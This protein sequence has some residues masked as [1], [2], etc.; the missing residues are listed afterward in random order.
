MNWF[1]NLKVRTRLLAAF[2]VM[3]LLTAIVGVIGIRNMSNMNDMT[4]K[5]Y[6]SELLGIA[7]IKEASLDLLRMVRAEKNLILSSTEADR[8]KFYADH[9]ERSKQL[10]NELNEAK[11]LFYSDQGKEMMA[12]IEGVWQG[13]QPVS[14]HL[15][16]VALA[17]NLQNM[18]K[19]VEI[20]N[21]VGREKVS[22]LNNLI[23]EATTH[24]EGEAK[25]FVEE[26]ASLYKDSRLFMIILIVGSICF[27]ISIGILI[28]IG[29]T[30]Q[31]GGEPGYI[32]DVAGKVAGGDLMVKF[33]SSNKVDTGVFV[34]MKVM[35]QK[36]KEIINDINAL[37]E[38]AREGQ[39]KTRADISRHQGDFAKIMD[40]INKTLDG[41]ITPL[42]TSAGYM[43][44]LSKGNIPAQ[45]T[46]EYKGDFNDIKKSINTM[47]ENLTGFATD[48]RT[49]ADNVA[50]G[51]QQ[52]SAGSEQLSQG[53]TEQAANAEEASSSVEEMSATIKQNA[54][55]A[56][57]TQKIAL[58][59]ASDAIE[60]GKAVSEAVIAMKDIAKKI[61]IIEEIAR[62]TNLLAL[63][64]AIEAAR[65]GEHGKGFAVVAAEV[66][67]LAERSQEA[68]GEIGQLS[69][70]SVE[71]AEKA[72]EMLSK[73]VP[74][75]QKTAELV[76]EITAASK[77]QTTG[78]DQINN[79][80]Q[81]LNQVIQQNAGAAE[82]MASTAEELSS[83]A[84][85]L[86][87]TVA[88]FKI[89]GMEETARA[90]VRKTSRTV[91]QLNVAHIAPGSKQPQ[92][93]GAPVKQGGVELH[94]DEAVVRGNGDHRDAAFE[95]F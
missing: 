7:H 20:S 92:K 46:E 82:E 35:V 53:T 72:G 8:K 88:F 93:A 69:S 63:N 38:A 74:D 40:G 89:Q 17:E 79:A 30:R 22:E 61:S 16:E 4:H 94:L 95:K 11:Q 49:A 36:L 84:E 56:Q 57:Q 60:S 12:K 51:S 52:L 31:L 71:V 59:S 85:Q 21:G 50:S 18:R 67:K 55:N 9:S 47:I 29:L 44:Q 2:M 27:G 78:A 45:I 86:Q 68:A 48:V 80:I 75:I 24:K 58:K 62:Q 39:L 37:T 43:D 15:M 5:M 90:G 66:R 33:E 23:E 83:Q 73:L 65:A 19:S 1:N 3:S 54:D 28:T 13:Y 14:N 81:Q 6:Q 91:H 34:A 87:S 26:T 70:S 10:T 32:A 77:E 76:Q 25:K 42:N 64:A 41:L